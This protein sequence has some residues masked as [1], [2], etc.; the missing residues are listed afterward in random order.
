MKGSATKQ[1]ILVIDDEPLMRDF[2]L[3]FLTRKSYQVTVA[4]SGGEALSVLKRD[5]YAVTFVDSRIKNGG[6]A[7]FLKAVREAA[8]ETQLVVISTN[9]TV[10]NAVEAAGSDARAAEVQVAGP[11]TSAVRGCGWLLGQLALR[12]AL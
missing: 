8:P 11:A 9:P 5:R 6:G 4:S 12:A 7:P 3:E 10:E 1:R 2:L